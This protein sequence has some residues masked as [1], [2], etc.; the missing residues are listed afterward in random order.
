MANYRLKISDGTTTID[1]YGSDFKV[2][3]GGL[4]LPDPNQNI[5]RYG[6]SISSIE[7]KN[8]KIQI[9]CKILGTSL[10]DLKS[11]IRSLR[12]LL[13]DATNRYLTGDYSNKVYLEYQWGDTAG[14]SIYFDILT[15][16]LEL[17]K[18]YLSQMLTDSHIVVGAVIEL[19][20]KPFARGSNVDITQTT[21]ENQDYSTNHNYMD[22]TDYGG[23]A[24]APAYIKI[25]H[26]EFDYSAVD[27]TTVSENLLTNGS[28]EL[29]SDS[30]GAP[31]S[32]GSWSSDSSHTF[33]RSSAYAKYGTYSAKL[34]KGN[35][36]CTIYQD[37]TGDLTQYEEKS[38]LAGMWVKADYGVRIRFKINGG[39]IWFFSNYHSGSGNFEYLVVSGT[40]PDTL[41]ALRIDGWIDDSATSG[42]TAYFDSACLV[43]LTSKSLYVAKRSGKDK[44]DDNLWIEG[45]NETSVTDEYGLSSN[46]DETDAS[47]SG[48]KFKRVVT[49]AIQ[50]ESVG[51][52]LSRINFDL[53][54]PPIGSFK[55]LA[56]CKVN[57]LDGSWGL[58]YLSG[59]IFQGPSESDFVN[60][61]AANTWELLDLGNITIPPTGISEIAGLSTSQLRLYQ[62]IAQTNITGASGADWL[63][64][65][66]AYDDNINTYAQYTVGS[67]DWSSYLEFTFTPNYYNRL[68]F[69]CIRQSSNINR[70]KIDI[71]NG[72]G[73]VNIYESGPPSSQWIYI[74]FSLTYCERARIRFYNTASASTNYIY[75]NEFEIW[76]PVTFD[77][78]YIF[79]L[80]I[81]ERYAVISHTAGD[82]LALDGIS[83]RPNIYV[84]DSSDKITKLATSVGQPLTIGR[85]KTRIYVLRDDLP[86]VTFV[87][88]V[89]YQPK[90]LT[91]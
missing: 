15:G 20:C 33:E 66:N 85:E 19:E 40:M 80:P 81:D 2:L 23:D 59:G 75:V 62:A 54:T 39:S 21:L 12:D 7:Y 61:S 67:N 36:H 31:D 14:Q 84:I 73:W 38:L 50:A 43:E 22:I 9:N 74:N 46:S 34:V 60:H 37:I 83:E 78:D 32:W 5:T 69:Y 77:L 91:I 11:N 89:K 79:L 49:S 35:G 25:K 82:T 51:I 8:R 24:E 30:N 6:Q 29:D 88:D 10:S 16:S 18:D 87:T 63:N 55:V 58:G 44:Y 64:H 17:P 13:T 41:T 90:Y 1:F 42:E 72:S 26:N 68:G 70:C 27:S 28:F 4:Y 52:L 3:E 57:S 65:S 53:T 71:Y 56:R 47:C 86:S 45:E 48:G 76:K